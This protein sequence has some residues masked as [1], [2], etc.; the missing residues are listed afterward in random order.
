MAVHL[1]IVHQPHH[2]ELVYQYAKEVPCR[3]IFPDY[4]LLPRYTYP[5]AFVDNLSVYKWMMRNTSKLKI[6]ENH[7]VVAGDSAGA[8]IAAC[9]INNYEKEHLAPPCGQ[10][11]IYPV[12]DASMSLESMKKY[13]DTPLWN[14]VNNQKMWEYYLNGANE[15]ERK[16]ASPIDNEL[17]GKVPETYIETTEFDCLH[18]EGIAYADKLKSIGASVMLNETQGT[19]HGYDSC[20]DAKITRSNIKKRIKFIKNL[21]NN[22]RQDNFP[23]CQ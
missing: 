19:F 23:Y 14:S 4:H 8:A 20:L 16:K 2:K 1:V 11:L 18:D 5:A 6:D 13:V 21:I 9:L 10:M 7:I 12:I 22:S 17:P 15:Q 3:V